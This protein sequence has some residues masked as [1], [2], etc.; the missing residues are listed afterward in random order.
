MEISCSNQEIISPII[1][2]LELNW[3][4][5]IIH[6]LYRVIALIL[7]NIVPGS[8]SYFT[9]LRVQYDVLRGTILVQSP[10]YNIEP[11]I[12]VCDNYIQPYFF[13]KCIQH[14]SAILF[15]SRPLA[16]K[17]SFT[18]NLSSAYQT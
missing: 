13:A 7:R 14:N 6:L 12:S 11:N 5:F 9:S 10:F 3:L 17:Y 1:H 8:I 18:R 16:C 2:L 15:I 4:G